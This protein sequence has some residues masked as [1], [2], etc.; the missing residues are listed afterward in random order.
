[1][2][3]QNERQPSENLHGSGPFRKRP[4]KVQI[5][6]QSNVRH[7]LI[8]SLIILRVWCRR[9]KVL[10][11]PHFLHQKCTGKLLL[12]S[13]LPSIG[14]HLNIL[15][16]VILHFL[17]SHFHVLILL[18]HTTGTISPQL[19]KYFRFKKDLGI[20]V[21]DVITFGWLRNVVVIRVI[22]YVL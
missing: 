5:K 6:R 2:D 13:L 19:S 3:E 22:W 21:G 10:H 9:W 4:G 12:L 17:V 15:H 7:Q 1:M 20:T 18:I 16:L 11:P 14:S 8:N